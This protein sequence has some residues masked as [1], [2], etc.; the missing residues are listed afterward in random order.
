MFDSLPR[1]FDRW[2]LVAPVIV[3]FIVDIGYNVSVTGTLKDALHDRNEICIMVWNA[4][5]KEG[6]DSDAR[7]IVLKEIADLL[8][9]HWDNIEGMVL[10]EGIRHAAQ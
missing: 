1:G 2:P 6:F 7:A 3:K 8:Y 10:L 9:F 4:I 5:T